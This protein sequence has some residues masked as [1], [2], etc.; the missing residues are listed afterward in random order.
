MNDNKNK[1]GRPSKDPPTPMGRRLHD[2]RK[3]KGWTRERLAEEAGLSVCAV[4][5]V[6]SEGHDPALFSA[7]CLADALGVSLDYLVLG[8]GDPTKT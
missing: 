4:R 8:K 1:G 3:A 2:L 7:I 6:E 5:S